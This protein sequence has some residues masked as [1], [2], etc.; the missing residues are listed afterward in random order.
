MVVLDE[1]W[2]NATVPTAPHHVQAVA[3]LGLITSA[4]LWTSRQIVREFLAVMSRPQTSDLVTF[5]WLHTDSA[6][7]PHVRAPPHVIPGTCTGRLSRLV[8][9]YQGSVGSVALMRTTRLAG[10]S[11]FLGMF[12]LFACGTKASTRA[13][14][15]GGAETAGSSA[16]CPVEQKVAAPA[17]STDCQVVVRAIDPALACG[18]AD[19]A[20][21]KAL[22][23]TCTSLPAAPWLSA[24]ADGAVTMVRTSYGDPGEA[25]ARMMTVGAASSRVEDVPALAGS[26][27]ALPDYSILRGAFS[28]NANGTKW[29]FSGESPGITVVRGTD[30]GWTKATAVAEPDPPWGDGPI[31]NDAKMVDDRLGYLTYNMRGDWAPHLL[32]WDGSCWTD[33]RIGEP[34]V[35]TIVVETDAQKQPWVAWISTQY[36][37][38]VQSVYLRSP[39]GDTQNLLA[40]VTS[41]APRAPL[42]I[43]ASGLDGKAAVPAVAANFRDGIRVLSENSTTDAGWQS[44]VIP[45]SAT[46]YTGAGDCPSVPP[47]QDFGNHCSGMTSCTYQSSGVGSGFDVARTQS[48]ALF[49]AWVAYSS[50]GTYALQEVAEG[51][52]FPTFD[53]GWTETSG[54]G[55]ADLVV[56]RL[57][58]PEPALTHFHFVMGSAVRYLINDVVMVARG[59]TLVVAAY[60][61][62]DTVPTLTYLEIDS[63]LLP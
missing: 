39:S 3:A 29:L 63:N 13:A 42:R 1:V 34:Q 55:T 48:G 17:L 10:L 38:Q 61:S 8:P 47:S 12:S 23:L 6:G 9:P 2:V 21:T 40:N 50:Q 15:A 25:L 62:G 41:D 11:L 33:Q 60:L 51:Y 30:A 35:D 28:T 45:E 54:T 56:A 43:L 26:V 22:D 24:T 49:A 32:T 57:T 31:L 53:C 44:L 46:A 20:I 37:A 14:D 59:D 58:G 5:V 27:R 7:L 19:C 36:P 52:E 16:L 4:N 18:S